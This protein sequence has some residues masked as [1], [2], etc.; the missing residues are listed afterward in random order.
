MLVFIASRCGIGPAG[1]K[2][3][4]EA[5]PDTMLDRLDVSGNPVCAGVTFEARLPSPVTRHA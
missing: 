5:L 3:L 1:M 4:A 2:E